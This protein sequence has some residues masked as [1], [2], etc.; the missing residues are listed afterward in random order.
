MKLET[1]QLGLGLGVLSII[2]QLS[3][4][5]G[6]KE[7]QTAKDQALYQMTAQAIQSARGTNICISWDCGGQVPQTQAP[8]A[9]SPVQVIYQPA[10]PGTKY[11]DPQ[12]QEVPVQIIDGKSYIAIAYQP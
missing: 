12:G 4:G 1:N 9:Q 5:L 11:V 2:L 3:G 8:Q 6:G 7:S 10:D